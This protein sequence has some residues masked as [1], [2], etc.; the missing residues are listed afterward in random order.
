MK[1]L[2]EIRNRILYQ[3]HVA[4]VLGLLNDR[5]KARAYVV[6]KKYGIEGIVVEKLEKVK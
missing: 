4:E 6:G 1:N 5:V 2:A 3:L